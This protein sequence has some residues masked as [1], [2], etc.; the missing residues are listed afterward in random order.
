MESELEQLFQEYITIPVVSA[1][2]KKLLKELSAKLKFHSSW[3]TDDV[4]REAIRF[5][6]A[7]NLSEK[8]LTLLVIAAAFH[9]AG[10]IDGPKDHESR[11]AKLAAEA[12]GKSGY[13]IEEIKRVTTMILDTKVT[14]TSKGLIQ[15]PT[16][17][18]S[19]YLLDADLSNFGR[20]DFFSRLEDNIAESGDNRETVLTRTLVFLENHIWLTEGARR[21][22]EQKQKENAAQLKAIL[23]KS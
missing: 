22:R 5:G 13:T 12:M 1:L 19:K 8:D 17:E 11:S 6:K 2:R 21:F 9:D 3:H 4:I 14:E 15:N 18:L 23:V 10:Y 20:E 16:S 7:D